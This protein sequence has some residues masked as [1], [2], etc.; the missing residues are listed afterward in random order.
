MQTE[1][2]FAFSADDLAANRRG[3]FS[4]S[5][6]RQMAQLNQVVRGPLIRLGLMLVVGAVVTLIVLQAVFGDNAAT[7]I[8]SVIISGGVFIFLV[9]A[10]LMIFRLTRVQNSLQVRS[11]TGPLQSVA[12]YD[13]TRLELHIEDLTIYAS[14]PSSER[15][16]AML[17]PG[18]IYAVYYM[19]YSPAATALS[20]EP[21]REDTD[22]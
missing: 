10:T 20:F 22:S 16:Y 8:L 14:V 12:I 15:A 19:G 18:A 5:Q 11:I 1:D 21:I 4:A 9:F 7:R 13:P 3:Q 17:E 2:V 6:Q